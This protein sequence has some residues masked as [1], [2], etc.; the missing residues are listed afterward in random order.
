MDMK[1]GSFTLEGAIILPIYLFLMAAAVSAGVTICQ[2]ISSQEEEKR[3]ED[4][5]LVDDFYRYETAG[6]VLGNHE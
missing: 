5:W 3:L 6:E 2:E 1:K 4:L